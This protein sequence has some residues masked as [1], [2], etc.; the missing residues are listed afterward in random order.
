[1]GWK[2]HSHEIG[3]PDIPSHLPSQGEQADRGSCVCDTR[4][5]LQTRSSSFR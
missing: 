3:H 2:I 1:M 5:N 4:Y